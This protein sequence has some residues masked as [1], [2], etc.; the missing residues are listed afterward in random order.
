MEEKYLPII[1]DRS[2]EGTSS[3]TQS[4]LSQGIRHLGSTSLWNE[5]CKWRGENQSFCFYICDINDMVYKK[6]SQQDLLL[7]QKLNVLADSAFQDMG[8]MPARE[9]LS[10]ILVSS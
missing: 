10:S 2:R 7:F 1:T 3:S 5:E 9:S 6:Q 8:V 4:E